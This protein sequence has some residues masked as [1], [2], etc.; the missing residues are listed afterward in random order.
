MVLE[1]LGSGAWL[2]EVTLDM[3]LKVVTDLKTSCDLLPVGKEIK[4]SLWPMLPPPR[5]S[6]NAHGTK[7]PWP[8]TPLNQVPKQI[9]PVLG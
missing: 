2:Q 8:V 6:A 9:F 5:G 1:T 4:H 3:P 7:Q